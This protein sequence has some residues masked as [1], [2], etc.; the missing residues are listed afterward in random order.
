MICIYVFL[1][2]STKILN[3]PNFWRKMTFWLNMCLSLISCGSGIDFL[4]RLVCEKSV[5]DDHFKGKP[6][7]WH[8][9][10][11]CAYSKPGIVNLCLV[12]GWV[13]CGEGS[14]INL[15]FS[16]MWFVYLRI[17]VKTCPMNCWTNFYSTPKAWGRI[18]ERNQIKIQHILFEHWVLGLKNN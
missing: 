12:H 8:V 6:F 11:V 3:F 18:L 15:E 9:L 5:K 13:E 17:C 16:K 7:Y 4:Q 14:K 10:K 1:R 2:K